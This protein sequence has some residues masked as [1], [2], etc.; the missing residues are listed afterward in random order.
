MVAFIAHPAVLFIVLLALFIGAV[1]FGAFVLRRVAVLP[2]GDREDFNIVQTSTLTLLALLVGFSLSMA[3][4]RYD[5]RK[6]LEEGEA[7]A[8]GTEYVRAD[9]AD[10]AQAVKIKS[11][12]IRY[13]KLRL[14]DYRTR[15]PEEL[16]RIGRDTSS[17]ET[18]L[19]QLATEVARDKPTPIGALVVAGMNDALNSQDYAE[20][21]RINHIPLGAWFLM[22]VIAIMACA[23]QGY[24][25]K[26]SLRKGLLL[27]ILPATVALSLALIS[28]ID[29]PR[30]GMI[31]VEPQN[32]A[33]LLQSI[34]K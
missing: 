31:H 23:V 34:D 19:W 32:L 2:E 27:T 4:N 25:A 30:G 17:V 21:A 24:G 11:A 5:Q 26:G 29:S 18:E 1:A 28:D 8:I 33:R 6:N 15:A 10:A 20:A 12:L 3:V 13:T 7:N 22:I 9:L 14:A 16:Q